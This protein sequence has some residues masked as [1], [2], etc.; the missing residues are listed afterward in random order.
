MNN[1][2]YAITSFFHFLGSMKFLGEY[3]ESGTSRDKN[4]NIID[5][6]IHFMCENIERKLTLADIANHV[7]LS[8]SHLSALFQ[9]KT[10]YSPLSYLIHLKIQKACHYL[11]FTDMKIIQICPKIGIEDPFYF[12]RIFTKTMGMSP[13]KYR[14]QKKG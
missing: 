9:K 11:D 6:V 13:S 5:E 4:Q 12:T 10:G 1:I 2:Y 14:N 7:S 3:R 8:A